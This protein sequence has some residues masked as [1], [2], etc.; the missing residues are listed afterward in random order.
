MGQETALFEPLEIGSESTK[1]ALSDERVLHGWAS[2]TEY[3]Q[4]PNKVINFLD[5]Q[6]LNS[7]F[8]QICEGKLCFQRPLSVTR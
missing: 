5:T 3:E 2:G 4:I 8:Q 6:E 7:L 1:K